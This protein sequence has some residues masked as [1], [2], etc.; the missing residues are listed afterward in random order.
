VTKDR[1][2]LSALLLLLLAGVAASVLMFW[3]TDYGPGVSPDSVIY[4]ETA[5]NL[6]AGDGFYVGERP[7]THFPPAYP[8]LLAMVGILQHGDVLQA[9]RLLCALFFGANVVLFGL[10]VQ[11]GTEYSWS[12]TIC[13]ILLFLCSAPIFSIHS[14]AWSEAP[15]IAF[16]LAAYMLVSLYIV[17]P[18]RYVL[19]AASICVSCAMVTRYLGVTLLPPIILGLLLTDRPL[20]HKIGDSL[21]VV[22]IASFPLASWLIRNIMT[23]GSATSRS[24]AVHLFGIPHAAQMIGT[25]YDMVLPI[26]LPGWRKIL[27]LGVAAILFLIILALLRRK[28]HIEAYIRRHAGAVHMV[29]PALCIVF[30]LTYILFLVISISFFDAFTPL[31]H[32]ILLPAFL[33]IAV[34]GIS[35]AWSLSLALD[36]RRVW[37]AFILFVS[38]SAII[39]SSRQLDTVVNIRRNGNGYTSQQWRSSETIASVLS[40]PEDMEIYSNGQDV[41]QFLTGRAASLIPPTTYPGTLQRN[42]GFEAQL[43][44]ICGEVKEGRAV[45]VYLNGIP[46]RWYEPTQEEVKSKCSLQVLARLDDGTIY[47]QQQ[48]QAEPGAAVP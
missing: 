45:I 16:T 13:A 8:L 14:M 43:Q 5:R 40:L 2:R 41:I 37:Y 44:I 21:V 48:A 4:I 9:G 42:L 12:A 15:L 10:A 32:R 22:I 35:S 7:M 24:F 29:L 39:N 25:M 34:A 1:R 28:Y 38:L 27:Q 36:S 46:W 11:L 26:S 30:C 20:K 18:R 33:A 47:A 6:L 31:R 23:T 19:L 17:R 3:S